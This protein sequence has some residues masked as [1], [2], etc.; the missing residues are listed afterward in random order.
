MKNSFMEED[1]RTRLILSGISE[2][3]ERGVRDFS[4]RRAAEM[5]GVSCAAPYR[6]FKDKESYISGII[7][8]VYE[9]WQLLCREVEKVHSD[10]GVRLVSAL[11]IVAVRFRLANERL[12]SSLF[13]SE[14]RGELSIS[15]FDKPIVNAVSRLLG[16]TPC[17]IKSSNIRALI[18]GYVDLISN[19]DLPGGEET[20]N[21]IREAIVLFLN[22]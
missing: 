12:L 19:G 9:K 5:A 11:A 8:Y 20:E 7:A 6:Y 17:E 4:L 18:H 3:G 22:S 15:D 21:A 16:G 14:H 1:V 13:I 2:L 10:D